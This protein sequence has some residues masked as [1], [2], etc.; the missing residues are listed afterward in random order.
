M[1]V[2]SASFFD[3]RG[4]IRLFHTN[5]FPRNLLTKEVSDTKLNAG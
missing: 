4:S 5:F 3:A 1:D 2:I